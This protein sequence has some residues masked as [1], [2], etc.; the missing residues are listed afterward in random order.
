MNEKLIQEEQ[1][2]DYTLKTFWGLPLEYVRHARD[3]STVV[4]FLKA[5]KKKIF[6]EQIHISETAEMTAINIIKN[7][8]PEILKLP[9]NEDNVVGNLMIKY[10]L[11]KAK[12]RIKLGDF[13]EGETYKEE[14]MADSIESWVHEVKGLL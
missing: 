1:F 11:K 7:S 6:K 9:I 10:V 4:V 3:I 2:E 8:Y 14:L 5:N 13:K 12:N